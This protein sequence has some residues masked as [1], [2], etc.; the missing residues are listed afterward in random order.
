MDSFSNFLLSAPSPTVPSPTTQLNKILHIHSD[1]FLAMLTQNGRD[2]RLANYQVVETCMERLQRHV[3]SAEVRFGAVHLERDSLQR[4]DIKTRQ[5]VKA[6]DEELLAASPDTLVASKAILTL[7]VRGMH[8][9]FRPTM[10]I[11][12]S[13]EGEEIAFGNTV[14]ICTN[15]TILHADRRFSTLQRHRDKERPALRV[16]ELIEAVDGIFPEVERY[17]EQDLALVERLKNQ[18]VQRTEWNALLGELFSQIQYVNRQRLAA[19]ISAVPD[20]LKKLPITA[21]LL[22]NIAAE[23]MAPS[24]GVYAWDGDWSNK[25]HLINFGT[26]VIKLERGAPPISWMETNANWASLVMARDFSQ[27]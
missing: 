12:L 18:P 14:N 19:N 27:N 9:D 11:N 24:H 3:G 16:Q 13:P 23:S 20:A 5:L 10:A 21:S 25:W 15:F 7:E 4:L 2:R 1:A 22:A 6:T 8:D 26:E 17:L